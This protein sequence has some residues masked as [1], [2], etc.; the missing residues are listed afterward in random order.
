MIDGYYVLSQNGNGRNRGRA[1]RD[2]G[3]M[4]DIYFKCE[5]GK[6]LAVDESGMG[7]IVHCPDC[8]NELLIPTPAIKWICPQCGTPLLAPEEMGGE[9]VQCVACKAN[10]SVPSVFFQTVDIKPSRPSDSMTSGR[11]NLSKH[12]DKLFKKCPACSERLPVK[13]QQCPHCEKSFSSKMRKIILVGEVGFIILAGIGIGGQLVGLWPLM[14]Q[15]PGHYPPTAQPQEV[16]APAITPPVQA[17]DQLPAPVLELPP[18]ETNKTMSVIEETK[19]FTQD[20]WLSRLEAS[21][22]RIS[23]QLDSSYPRFS[24]NQ[25]LSLRKMDGLV[26]HGKYVS[27]ETEKATLM[28]TNQQIAVLLN[29][30]DVYDRLRMDNRFRSTWIDTQARVLSR[31]SLEQEGMKRPSQLS[32]EP[33]ADQA[34]AMGDPE[35][36][37]Q[38]AQ[39]Y[40]KQKDFSYAFL[41]YMASALQRHP[42]AQYALGMIYYQGVGIEANRKEG[43]KWLIVSASLGNTKAEQFIQQHNISQETCE[44][45]LQREKIREERAFQEQAVRAKESRRPLP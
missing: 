4:T 23:K 35:A 29:E 32:S 8:G 33:S 11:E 41:Y 43:L 39:Q 17:P 13:T 18:V 15:K 20:E 27:I 10:V 25:D 36:Q 7:R 38:L 21:R 1:G 45:V 2:S 37:Y 40:Y 22:Q 24:T 44:K 34:L 6:R 30:I 28:A 12:L 14:L 9:S 31:K 16:P 26:I 19:P 42:G 3:I 5:C